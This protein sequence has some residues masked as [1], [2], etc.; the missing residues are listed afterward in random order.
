M[1]ATHLHSELSPRQA[2]GSFHVP[3]DLVAAATI[4]LFLTT[5]AVAA[6]TFISAVDLRRLQVDDLATILAGLCFAAFIAL[7][8]V[9]SQAGLGS[10]VSLLSAD[11]V[12]RSLLYSNILDIMYTPIM[13]AAKVSI[14]VQVDRMFSGN[15]QRL[16]FWSVRALAYVNALCYTAM[17]FANVFACTPRAKIVDPTVSGK[18]IP[19]NNIII[20]SS[21]VNVAS[22]VL[23]LLFAVWGVSRLQLSGRRQTMV[24]VVFSIG[25]FACVASVCRLAFGV[26]V[27]K[28]RNYTQTIW[29]VHM[30][31]LAE[32]TAIMYIACCP[33]FP[34]LIQYVRG[35]KTVKPALKG[36]KGEKDIFSAASSISSAPNTPE[37]KHGFSSPVITPPT[38][39]KGSPK[40]T[41]PTPTN[42][43]PQGS[44]TPPHGFP[45]PQKPTS[46]SVRV[47]TGPAQGARSSRK[48]IL[49]SYNRPVTSYQ[50]PATALDPS[51]PRTNFSHPARPT[52][53]QLIS[54]SSLAPRY[55]PS[56]LTTAIAASAERA[57]QNYSP[58][59]KRISHLSYTSRHTAAIDDILKAYEPP[60]PTSSQLAP[61]PTPG[62]TPSASVPKTPKT[63]TTPR[64][65][66]TRSPSLAPPPSP[67]MPVS[68][69]SPART[70]FSI[71]LVESAVRMKIMPVYFAKRKKS[72]DSHMSSSTLGSQVMKPK[73]HSFRRSKHARAPSTPA[74]QTHFEV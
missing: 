54:Q 45:G 63:P 69:V 60:T 14:L 15:K 33:A 37:Q 19:Q 71:A 11:A 55:V 59:E 2:D 39:P 50:L 35:T 30:W 68:P 42:G 56:E 72:H 40:I 24:A 9:A 32:I 57:L 25:S 27:D 46:A 21:T 31:S 4:C 10:H 29:P 66:H 5:A 44:P 65:T 43:S 52:Q 12:K 38:P 34:R 23:V 22:D 3:S 48:S 13:L 28:N 6:K 64:T 70:E 1:P 18:C 8:F 53:Q 58:V 61:P 67:G 20:T 62:P 7:M 36:L 17:F 73:M 49:P 16:I 51:K 74:L 41:P 26:Q 47:T